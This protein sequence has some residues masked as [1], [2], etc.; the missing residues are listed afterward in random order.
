MKIAESPLRVTF[1]R[2]HAAFNIDAD[3]KMVTATRPA[4][5]GMA[6]TLS[7]AISRQLLRCRDRRSFPAAHFSDTPEDTAA[8]STIYGELAGRI[9]LNFASHAVTLLKQAPA[10]A[11]SARGPEINRPSALIFAFL[12]SGQEYA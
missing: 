5:V 6:A 1:L 3:D 11:A 9:A 4:S 7:P 12:I 10:K 2:E 8:A